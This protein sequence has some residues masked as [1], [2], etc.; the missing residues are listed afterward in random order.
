MAKFAVVLTFGEEAPRLATRPRHREYLQRLLADGK[1]H[2]SG[3]WVDDSG[4]LIVYEAADAAEAEALLAADP[5]S[6][7]DSII[8]EAR[9]QEW[10]RVYA[11][12]GVA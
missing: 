2:E 3:P 7:T 4:A 9:I 10:N 5:Y 12:D 6:Q 1:L 8:A 11:A